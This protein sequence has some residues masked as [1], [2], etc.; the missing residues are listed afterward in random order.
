MR[1]LTYFSLFVQIFA[2][3]MI[4]SVRYFP[5]EAALAV[6]YSSGPVGLVWI[7]YAKKCPVPKLRFALLAVQLSW[8][9]CVLTLVFTR[10][11]LLVRLDSLLRVLVVLLPSIALAALIFRKPSYGEEKSGVNGAQRGPN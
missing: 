8:L 6:A 4:L 9:T 2:C 3:V 1:F 5:V 7:F 11:Y 10:V